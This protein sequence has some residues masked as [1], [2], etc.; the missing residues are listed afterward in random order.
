MIFN[1]KRYSLHKQQN[2]WLRDERSNGVRIQL[3]LHRIMWEYY[4]GPIPEGYHIHHKDEDRSNN[5]LS[6]LECLSPGSHKGVHN[7]LRDPLK[8]SEAVQKAWTKR[9]P[10]QKKCGICEKPYKTLAPQSKWWS[11][12][13]RQQNYMNKRAAS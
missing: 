4:F 5:C 9:L 7:S 2:Y 10:V 11:H 8:R 13:C 6:N 1:N 3:R 12:V